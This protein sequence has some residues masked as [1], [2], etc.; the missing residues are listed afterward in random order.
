MAAHYSLQHISERYA[1]DLF[2][3]RQ[4]TCVCV[5]G[6]LFLIFKMISHSE[7]LFWLEIRKCANGKSKFTI[8]LH[9]F[10]N[11]VYIQISDI[12]RITQT[13]KHAHTRPFTWLRFENFPN[14]LF[15]LTNFRREQINPDCQK[16]IVF[17]CLNNNKTHCRMNGGLLKRQQRR[18]VLR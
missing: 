13:H 12:N 9:V 14:W 16:S 1:R 2:G 10:I 18:F 4:S 3:S 5:R 15:G 8:S 17:V 7:K 11:N 6:N